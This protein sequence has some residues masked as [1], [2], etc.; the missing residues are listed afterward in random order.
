M[1]A[2]PNINDKMGYSPILNAIGSI[3]KNNNAILELMLKYG[4]DLDK[5][6]G[7]MTL[8]E[9]RFLVIGK[10]W[11]IIISYLVMGRLIFSQQTSL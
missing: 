8:K 6:E 2:N 7:E 11:T 1:G 3:N 5:A 10:S 9:M 4:L